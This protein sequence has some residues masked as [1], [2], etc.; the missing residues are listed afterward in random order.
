VKITQ[1]VK[2]FTALK[3]THEPHLFSV[4]CELVEGEVFVVTVGPSNGRWGQ[5]QGHKAVPRLTET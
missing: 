2:E 1:L 5:G 3:Q 4:Y